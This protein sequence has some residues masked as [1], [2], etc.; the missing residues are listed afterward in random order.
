MEAVFN[1]P[2]AKLVTDVGFSLHSL[3]QL[4]YS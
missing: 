2:P 4:L 3:V 1:P